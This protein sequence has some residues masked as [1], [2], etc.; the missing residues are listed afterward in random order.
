MEL[1]INLMG[2]V[3]VD[4]DIVGQVA[5]PSIAARDLVVGAYVL[6]EDSVP[7]YVLEGTAGVRESLDDI[8]E[9]RTAIDDA[10]LD[11][12]G[13]MIAMETEGAR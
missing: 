13:A 8:K 6:E 9:H 4:G 7:A 3:L 5:F 10:L 11:I 12:R 1:E 2:D